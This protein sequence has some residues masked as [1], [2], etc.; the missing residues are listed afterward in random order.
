MRFILDGRDR[1]IIGLS[2]VF[3]VQFSSISI[4]ILNGFSILTRRSRIYRFCCRRLDPLCMSALD[5]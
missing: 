5:K 1:E 3:P 2:T 4:F